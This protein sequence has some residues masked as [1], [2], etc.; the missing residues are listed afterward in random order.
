MKKVINRTLDKYLERDYATS[1]DYFY[2]LRSRYT[3]CLSGRKWEDATKIMV[4]FLYSLH[5]I[6]DNPNDSSR[7]LTRIIG[8]EATWLKNVDD[9]IR[10][11]MDQLARNMEDK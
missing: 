10:M 5:T 1:E 8:D 7:I 3:A 6:R 9:M 2:M 4:L 11:Q